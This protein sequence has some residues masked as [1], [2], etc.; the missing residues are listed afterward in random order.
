LQSGLQRRD[1]QAGLQRAQQR[2]LIELAAERIR[3][4]ALGRRFLNDL[5]AMF[6]DE[7]ASEPG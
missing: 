2:G 5:Q 1:R 7:E 6:L 4:T 3:P